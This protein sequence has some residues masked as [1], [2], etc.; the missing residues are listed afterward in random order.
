M[1]TE[2][3]SKANNNLTPSSSSRHGEDVCMMSEKVIRGDYT[4][5]G[6]QLRHEI[7]KTNDR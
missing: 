2:N 3:I 7:Q 5:K 4:L 1:K 6:H